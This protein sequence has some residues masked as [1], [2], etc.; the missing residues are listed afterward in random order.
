M[1]GTYCRLGVPV[2]A[3]E[4]IDEARCWLHEARGHRWRAP[5]NARREP[6]GPR[7]RS[8]VTLR[9]RSTIATAVIVMRGIRSARRL[10]LA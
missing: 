5:A 1:H 7:T 4:T 3:S 8:V 10:A 9:A 6:E 2:S